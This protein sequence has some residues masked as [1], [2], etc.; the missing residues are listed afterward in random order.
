MPSWTA[1][2]CCRFRAGSLLP[3]HGLN[4]R[5]RSRRS[6]P[7]QA[8]ERKAAAGCS[9]P[10]NGSALRD[11]ALENLAVFV[12]FCYAPEA[13]VVTLVNNRTNNLWPS[14]EECILWHYRH[15]HGQYESQP[16][17]TA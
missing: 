3:N 2:A 11:P 1:A 17:A 6:A 12:E 5:W 10:K 4:T 9:S 13:R 14:N 8:V 15:E 7:Q 16:P